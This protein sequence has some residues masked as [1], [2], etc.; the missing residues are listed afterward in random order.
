MEF[1]DEEA[2]EG[3]CPRSQSHWSNRT[4]SPSEKSVRVL[5]NSR[6]TRDGGWH[7]G[8]EKGF[9]EKVET[10]ERFRR[11]SGDFPTE[12]VRKGH[13]NQRHQR[14]QRLGGMAGLVLSCW[15]SA[16]FQWGWHQVQEA[17]EET[18]SQ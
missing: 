15:T 9:T 13:S 2:G 4:A 18:Q 5:D 11:T 8:G 16:E 12:Q 7:W 14:V 17:E 1:I 6:V 3:T 10:H